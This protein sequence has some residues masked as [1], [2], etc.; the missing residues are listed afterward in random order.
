VTTDHLGSPRIV[1][2]QNGAVI[3][4]KDFAAFGD[5]TV[6]PQ[7]NTG[8]GYNPL[9]VRQDYTGYQ[10]DEESGLEYSVAR[11]YNASHGRYTSVDPLTPSATIK[12][13]QTFNR[14]SYVTNSP[15]KFTDPLG[16]MPYDA[17]NGWDHVASG[18]W[19]TD[20]NGSGRETGRDIISAAE[21]LH[22]RW[23]QAL[24]DT[25]RVVSLIQK[26]KISEAQAIAD[27]SDNMVRIEAK[28]AR[29]VTTVTVLGE[30]ET[31][32]GNGDYSV[33][34]AYGDP[35]LGT[36]NSGLNF[37]RAAET[38][39]A[40]LEAL[41][42]NVI[43]ASISS[44]DGLNEIL[45]FANGT[46]AWK[47]AIALE[48]FGHGSFDRLFLGETSAANSNLTAQ[49]VG[50]L[51]KPATLQYVRLNAC[52]TGSGETRS[53][54]SMLAR[55]LGVEVRASTGPTIF[56]SL[57]D[58]ITSRGIHPNTGPTYLVNDGGSYVY[59]KP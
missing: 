46:T 28:E 29:V 15:Y 12:D 14:Y 7:R 1:T 38:R 6:T 34:L 41:G 35:G 20:L 53:I 58:R 57:P 47:P 27:K 19:G 23:F 2:D 26:G 36:H 9:N 22:D 40:E 25:K 37:R 18:F 8:L 55:Q 17:D 31:A 44:V 45:K 43:Y 52:Y 21:A 42:F 11:Y 5:E 30:S 48:I 49:N 56:S 32:P 3:S 33:I 59:Y 54:A 13:P 24:Y 51:T 4:R 39:G 50:T 16:L 10:K